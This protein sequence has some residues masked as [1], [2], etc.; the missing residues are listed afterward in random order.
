M[1]PKTSFET[2]LEWDSATWGQALS[3]WLDRS[4]VGVR[5]ARVLE[6]GGRDGG[7]SL[8]LAEMGANVI[9]SDLDGPS[10]KARHLHS[11]CKLTG[12]IEYRNLDATKM[13][14]DGVADIVIF[15]SVLGGIG[16]AHGPDGQK[17]ALTNMYR[18]LRPGGCLL[19]AENL[20]GAHL[21][22]ALRRRFV[23]WGERWRYVSRSELSEWLSPFETT[24]FRVFG[25][26]ALLGR[27]ERQRRLLAFA[28][29][30]LFDRVAPDAW[31]YVV[32][33]CAH[34]AP[35]SP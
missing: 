14:L 32:A 25:T 30:W 35:V 6:V 21:V 8:W 3:F 10:E 34:K 23:P 1:R 31:R 11:S 24:Q 20:T 27:T 13:D 29:R 7:L 15:K 19:F 4:A 26:F 17:A 33:G 28:D 18:A 9:C 5:G 2:Y 22:N 12:S 16:G